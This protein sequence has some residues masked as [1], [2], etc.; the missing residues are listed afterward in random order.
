MHTHSI[1]AFRHDHVFLGDTHA[2]SERKTFSVVAICAAIMVAEIVGRFW[3]G[4]SPA[5]M[6]N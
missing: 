6:K 3:F 5:R 4:S 1:D 2:R